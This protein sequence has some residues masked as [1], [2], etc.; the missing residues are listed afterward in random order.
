[1]GTYAGLVRFDGVRFVPWPSLSDQPLPDYRIWSLLATK[2][3]SLWI[4]TQRGL[5]RW[6]TGELTAYVNPRGRINSI[7]EDLH[8]DVWVARSQ[9]TDGAGPLCRVTGSEPRCFGNADG[10]PMRTAMRLAKDP[11]GHIWISGSEGLCQWT[12]QSS[13]TY[14]QKKLKQHGVLLGILALVV[15]RNGDLWISLEQPG[16]SLQ[17]E[18][19]TQGRWKHQDLP[20]L[21]ASDQV[22]SAL[23]E[24]RDGAVWVGTGRQGVYRIY[25]ARRTILRVPTA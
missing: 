2:D 14:F 5:A 25:R 19:F 18:H 6:K 22:I 3:G 17:L 1:M 4:G 13:T 7:L 15:A 20:G 16:G 24:D 12:P 11:S 21:S 8:G 23:Y 10:I 9:I